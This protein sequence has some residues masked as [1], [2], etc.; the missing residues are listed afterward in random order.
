MAPTSAGPIRLG[1]VPEHFN[2]PWRLALESG[3]LGAV[4][5]TWTDQPGGTG[6]M[7]TALADGELDV[8]SILTEG[9]VAAIDRG[10]AATIIGVYVESPLQWG[11]HVP[12]GSD[13]VELDDCAGQR[14]AIS[15]RLSGSH[16]MAFV[17]AERHG[18]TLTEE[19]LVT[20]GDLDG[21]RAAF[22]AGDAAVFLWDRYM[23]QPL[24]DAGEF[25]R[26]GIEPTPWP[27][28]VIAAR[29]EALLGRTAEVGAVVDAVVAEAT[30][31]HS[32]PDRI[33][34]ITDRYGL[35]VATAEA[36][37]DTTVFAPRAAVDPAM[38]AGCAA[39]LHRVGI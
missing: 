21:A 3:A 20:V 30:M 8:V 25:R 36:W 23:T 24:V 39:V 17:Q 38:L 37:F 7:V 2:L 28:F 13:L 4:D 18:W 35:D 11:V 32:R 10:L 19:Q 14:V 15:R 27:S 1:G 9:T 22:A 12:A 5:A 29:T 33:D 26:V 6:Q 16:L 34:L 31:L